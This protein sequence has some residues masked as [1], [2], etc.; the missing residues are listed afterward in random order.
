MNIVADGI[1][2]FLQKIDFMP[3]DLIVDLVV[4]IEIESVN[5]K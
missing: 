2:A 1:Y 5:T 3:D 4:D